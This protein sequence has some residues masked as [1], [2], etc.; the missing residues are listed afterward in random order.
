M[1]SGFS[2]GPG[3]IQ[4]LVIEEILLLRKQK[5]ELLASRFGMAN[6]IEILTE[7]LEEARAA[8]RRGGAGLPGVMLSLATLTFAIGGALFFVS[9]H[10]VHDGLGLFWLTGIAAGVAITFIINDLKGR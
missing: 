3:N 8:A 5:Q 9:R 1:A 4:A 10:G 7:Q 2:G 6:E